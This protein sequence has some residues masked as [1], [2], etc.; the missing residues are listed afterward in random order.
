VNTVSWLVTTLLLVQIA[1]PSADGSPKYLRYTGRVRA[2]AYYLGLALNDLEYL[3]ERLR[4]LGDQ[5]STQDTVLISP[6][7]GGN[8]RGDKTMVEAYRRDSKHGIY[9]RRIWRVCYERVSPSIYE[10]L[11]TSSSVDHSQ[12]YSVDENW[13][14]PVPIPDN[15]SLVDKIKGW[16]GST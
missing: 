2:R 3:Q 12:V 5:R 4:L 15:S 11:A 7:G 9:A 6:F 16:L 14:L 13:S 8:E 1:F 10:W